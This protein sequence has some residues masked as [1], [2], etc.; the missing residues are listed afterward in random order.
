MLISEFI[1]PKFTSHISA[2]FPPLASLPSIH[3]S[4]KSI[5]VDPQSTEACPLQIVS[6][7][8]SNVADRASCTPARAF[9]MLDCLA[10]HSPSVWKVATCTG[11][12]HCPV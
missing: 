6:A 8:P 12:A 2:T 4:V 5:P 11:A 3:N 1:K 10:S 7:G 9:P